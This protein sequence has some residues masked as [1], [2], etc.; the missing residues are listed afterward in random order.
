MVS[1]FKL[2]ENKHDIYILKFIFMILM[3]TLFSTIMTYTQ[4]LYLCISLFYIMG[5]ICIVIVNFDVAHPY[6][7]FNPFFILYST[8]NALLIITNSVN[9]VGAYKLKESLFISWIAYCIFII[10]ITPKRYFFNVDKSR[11]NKSIFVTK[12]IYWGSVIGIMLMCFDVVRS[13][14]INKADI[15]LEKSLLFTLGIYSIQIFTFSFIILITDKLNKKEKFDKKFIL[16]QLFIALVVIFIA[17]ER[18]FFMRLILILLIMYSLLIRKIPGIKLMI[19]GFIGMISL[20]IFQNL[21]NIFLKKQIESVG[22]S[23]V[24]ES[25]LGG[26]FASAGRNLQ[27]LVQNG[28][29]SIFIN[30]NTFFT[31]IKFT[32]TNLPFING[33]VVTPTSWFNN[34]FYFDYVQRGGGKGFS[35]IGEGYINGGYL[36]VAVWFIILALIVRYVYKKSTRNYVWFVAYL[37]I[38]PLSIYCL[39]ADFAIYFSHILKY[40]VIPLSILIV[41]DNVKNNK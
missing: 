40:I 21:K 38:I 12:M 3:L 15:K 31:D 1:N 27:I 2:N 34:T 10:V 28:M 32:F 19:Y 26:E 14:A 17:G 6:T 11:F 22:S 41:Y 23:N 5:F 29:D 39:R 13:G 20:S 36:G 9:S 35:L 37:L 33:D 18:D 30:N 7:W 16:F 8:S 4:N 25:I 24:L